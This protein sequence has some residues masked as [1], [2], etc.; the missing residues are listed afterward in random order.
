MRIFHLAREQKSLATP[1]LFCRL[2]NKCNS[3]INVINNTI[4]KTT[5]ML[6]R[7][8]ENHLTF[9]DEHKST[10]NVIWYFLTFP[11]N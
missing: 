8:Y 2:N 1:T 4:D 6:T 5:A 11:I 3:N 9:E 10:K 7:T